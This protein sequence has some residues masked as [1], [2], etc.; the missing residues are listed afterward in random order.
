MGQSLGCPT[1]LTKPNKCFLEWWYKGERFYLATFN[2]YE[3]ALK[4]A[5]TIESEIQFNKFKPENYRGENSKVKKRYQFSH[6]Y[7]EWLQSRQLDVDKN[8]IAP[9]YYAKLKS[10]RNDFVNFFE[11]EDIRTIKTYGI[12]KFE[13]SVSASVSLKTL[14]NKLM[15]LRKFFHDLSDLEL[16][17]EM[18]KFRSIRTPEPEWKWIDEITQMNIL[19]YIPD[20]D[21]PIFEFLFATGLRP[22]EVRALKWA[23]INMKGEYIDIRASFSKGIYRKITKTKNSWQIPLFNRLKVVLNRVPRSLKTDFVFWYGNREPYGEN[24]LRCLWHAACKAAGIDGLTL[25][26]GTRH[27]FASQHI[28]NGKQLELIGAMMGH[29]STQTTRR[30]AHLNKLEALKKA[31]DS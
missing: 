27:S 25:Y 11:D 2:S 6:V 7:D 9:S 10:Y 31:F 16:I 14:K 24:K 22:A 4:K 28:N 26:Q 20:V 12:K 29:R 18:P 15:V 3:D 21:K 5:I 1:C 19:K 30:Y 23:D 17:D 13:E 8:I